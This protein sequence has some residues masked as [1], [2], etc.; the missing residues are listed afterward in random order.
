MDTFNDASPIAD[1]NELA[2]TPDQWKG[3]RKKQKKPLTED[4]LRRHA[5]TKSKDFRQL[6]EFGV[7]RYDAVVWCYCDSDLVFNGFKEA[8][9][10]M[11]KQWM[12]LIEE[13][14]PSRVMTHEASGFLLSLDEIDGNVRGP[15]E[16]HRGCRCIANDFLY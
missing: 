5:E 9:H 8:H 14:F 3:K 6:L 11:R 4:E 1:D 2:R 13:Y 15:G 12:S 16:W 7:E 10:Y